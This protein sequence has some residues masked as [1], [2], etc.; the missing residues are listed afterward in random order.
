MRGEGGREHK[1]H[2]TSR[3]L[4]PLAA[5]EAQ[6]L[7]EKYDAEDAISRERDVGDFY[8]DFRSRRFP[9]EKRHF[10]DVQNTLDAMMIETKTLEVGAAETARAA[11]RKKKAFRLENDPGTKKRARKAKKKKKTKMVAKSPP[12]REKEFSDV[13]CLSD[14]EDSTDEE[15][16]FVGSKEGKGRNFQRRNEEEDDEVIIC[17]ERG[18]GKGKQQKQERREEG[19]NRGRKSVNE[20]EVIVV[21]EKESTQIRQAREL[22]ERHNRSN[23]NKKRKSSEGGSDANASP[24][25]TRLSARKKKKATSSSPT[26]GPRNEPST[27]PEPKGPQPKKTPKCVICLDEIEKPTAT[28]CGHVY[29]DQC[30]RELIRAQKTKSRC[31]QCRKKVGLSGLTKLILDD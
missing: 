19:R 16:I 15:I 26:K 13:I 30:I 28:K 27:T 20:E 9:K 6:L 22:L 21:G 14:E 18:G 17:G 31:P 2:V 3:L 12:E 8:A 24:T 4:F 10:S 7:L 1:K 23:T 25:G 29:C 5:T 11:E